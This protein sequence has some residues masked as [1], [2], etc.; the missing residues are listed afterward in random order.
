MHEIGAAIATA[1]SYFALLVFHYYI[2]K[3][4]IG[5]YPFKGVVSKNYVI[6][7]FM[8][9]CL[10]FLCYDYWIA[11][12]IIAGCVALVLAYDVVKRRNIL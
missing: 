7:F 4:K 6:V 2:G 10:L 8:A 5:A 9:I 12:W 3:N 1:I 11:R